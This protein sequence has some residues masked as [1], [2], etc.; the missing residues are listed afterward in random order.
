M[1]KKTA[2]TCTVI[3]IVIMTAML[4][5]MQS[6]KEENK[7]IKQ[8]TYYTDDKESIIEI[9]E[10][11]TFEFLR[12]ISVNWIVQGNY[13]ITDDKL[14]LSDPSAGEYE[15][16]IGDNDTLIFE[17]GNEYTNKIIDI[18]T[19]YYLNVTDD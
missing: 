12:H 16:R 15:F 2:I 10:G 13:T 3:A 18:G 6:N 7:K 5:I 17:K 9:K 14:I 19:E 11:G 4:L 1:I 8:G